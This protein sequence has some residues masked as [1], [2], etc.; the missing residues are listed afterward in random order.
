M[1]VSYLSDIKMTWFVQLIK[2]TVLNKIKRKN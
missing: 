2:E 1:H